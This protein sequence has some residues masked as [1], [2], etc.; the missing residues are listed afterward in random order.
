MAGWRCPKCKYPNDEKAL[1]CINCGFGAGR[2]ATR[3][4]RTVA[5]E[6]SKAAVAAAPSWLSRRRWGKTVSVFSTY[7]SPSDYVTLLIIPAIGIVASVL[8]GN[9]FLALAFGFLGTYLIFPTESEIKR[10][11]RLRQQQKEEEISSEKARQ[12][13][14]EEE[15]MR[16]IALRRARAAEERGRRRGPGEGYA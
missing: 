15:E 5:I 14:E 16:K 4:E 7:K 6:E 3:E 11:A 12:K 1:Y 13:T 10:R 9:F 2:Q 8:F